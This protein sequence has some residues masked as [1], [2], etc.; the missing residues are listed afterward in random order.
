M[1]ATLRASFEYSR[2][3]NRD[4]G[5]NLA[6]LATKGLLGPATLVRKKDL[7]KPR[8][9]GQKIVNPIRWGSSDEDNPMERGYY[10]IEPHHTGQVG[11]T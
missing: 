3:T 9:K 4:Y 8:G 7:T 5:E 10:E 11:E 6:T 2:T 1:K